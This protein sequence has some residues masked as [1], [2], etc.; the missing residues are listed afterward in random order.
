MVI[1]QL[2]RIA[3][4]NGEEAAEELADTYR[5]LIRIAQQTQRQAKRVVDVLQTVSAAAGQRLH[6]QFE[7]ILP[8][9]DQ[10]IDQTEQRVIDDEKLSAGEKIVSLF[11]PHTQIVKRQ[12]AGTATEFGRKLW[13]EEVEGAIVSGDRILEEPG[14]DDRYLEQSLTDHQQRF[15]HPPWLLAGQPRR[16]LAHQ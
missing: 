12:K 11:E 10:V 8:F 1:Q 15:G 5:R 4:R 16:L 14:Q 3:R 2:H 7:E 6:Q 13:L 9:M